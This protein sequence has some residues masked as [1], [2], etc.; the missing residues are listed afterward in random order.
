MNK[1]TTS[2]LCICF[3]LSSALTIAQNDQDFI[4]DYKVSKVFPPLSITKDALIQAEHVDD[5]NKYYKSSWVEEY[6]SVSITAM[7]NGTAITE[8]VSNDKLSEAQ[9]KI[10][11]AADP[12]SKITVDILY[13]PNNTLKVKEEK[14]INFSFILDPDQD[15]QFPGG[16]EALE[17]YIEKT[18]Q[19][20]IPNSSFDQHLVAAIEF[21]IDESGN[22]VDA[23][24]Y[25]HNPYDKNEQQE[26]DKILL[27]AICA[28]P[29]WIPAQ[30]TDGPKVKTNYVLTAGDHNSC[31][32]NFFNVKDN[33]LLK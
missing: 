13:V 3:M 25:D 8:T 7:N 16:E 21:T 15:A 27:D 10:M 29:Q 2:I 1:I 18:A 22:V 4:I 26:R 14:E 19:S 32:I 24:I 31:V 28:M 17:R 12:A 6:K 33:Q 20:L 5:L 30:Y 9:K 11:N 23:S